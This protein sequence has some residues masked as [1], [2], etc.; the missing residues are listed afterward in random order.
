MNLRAVLLA[1]VSSF[2]LGGLW[3]SSALFGRAW[4]TANNEPKQDAWVRGLYVRPEYRGRGVDRMLLS[5]VER[6]AR[7]RGFDALY[8]ATTRIERLALRR[9]WRVIRRLDHEGEPMAW[10]RRGPD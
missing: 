10:L 8:A 2:I 1:A 7:N 5:A 4:K 9:G 3:Y 6:E